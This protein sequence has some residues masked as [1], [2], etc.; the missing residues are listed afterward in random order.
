MDTLP[1]QKINSTFIVFFFASP[2]N[3]SMPKSCPK[4]A[5]VLFEGCSK[6]FQN[7]FPSASVGGFYQDLSIS[8]REKI[9]R[10]T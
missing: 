9:I 3:H 8:C 6:V 4:Q 7:L 5:N 1:Q 2:V 10:K